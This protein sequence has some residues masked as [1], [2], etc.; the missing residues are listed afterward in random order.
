MLYCANIIIKLSKVK[1]MQM[2]KPFIQ[3]M[4]FLLILVIGIYFFPKPFAVGFQ[5]LQHHTYYFVLIL[6][7]TLL[8]A[9]ILAIRDFKIK[10]HISI[11]IFLLLV[12]VSIFAYAYI[13]NSIQITTYL[14]MTLGILL[15]LYAFYASKVHKDHFKRHQ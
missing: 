13:K 14:M 9:Y 1:V 3:Q 10:D 11:P 5:Y 7:I 15:F 6:E 8:G 12:G 2:S 4:S